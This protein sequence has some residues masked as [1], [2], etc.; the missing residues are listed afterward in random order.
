MS[1]NGHVVFLAIC[2]QPPMYLL[3]PHVAASEKLIFTLSPPEELEVPEAE[4]NVI[5]QLL[6][7]LHN[8]F[9]KLNNILP[10]G[11]EWCH[12]GT[13]VTVAGESQ[14]CLDWATVLAIQST[15]IS[16]QL[17]RQLVELTACVKY[18]YLLQNLSAT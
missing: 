1:K 5:K 4:M 17:W 6:K 10:L 16:V 12:W 3:G 8:W 7:H 13:W 9:K 2:G 14:W 18:A 15:S 11:S